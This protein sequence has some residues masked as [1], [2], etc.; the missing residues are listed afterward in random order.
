MGSADH[1]KR[2]IDHVQK[3][4]H[5]HLPLLKTHVPVLARMMLL[6]TRH[7]GHHVHRDH[8]ERREHLLD[9]RVALPLLL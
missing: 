1:A 4:V 5:L 7:A 9:L 3:R 6:M 2:I 8:M